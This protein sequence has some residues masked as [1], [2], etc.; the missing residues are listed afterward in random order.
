[1]AEEPGALGGRIRAAAFAGR[2]EP[3]VMGGEPPFVGR[4]AEHAQVAAAF[5][6]VRRGEARLASIEGDPGIGKSRLAAEVAPWAMS[7]GAGVLRGRALEVGGRLPYQPV[8]DALRATLDDA[9]LLDE[10]TPL[11]VS[12]L[13]RLLP[14]LHERYPELPPPAGMAES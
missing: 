7:Q 14:E 9:A 6:A 12:E 5:R 1:R 4:L 2:V 10:L 13:A 8:V 11:W 3:A